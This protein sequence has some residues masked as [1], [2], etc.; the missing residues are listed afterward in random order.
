MRSVWMMWR[1][2]RQWR[3]FSGSRVVEMEPAVERVANV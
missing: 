3:L 1:L 2:W